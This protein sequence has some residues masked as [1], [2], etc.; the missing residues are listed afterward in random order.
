MR[1]NEVTAHTKSRSVPP[2]KCGR[3]L[4]QLSALAV[5]L[6]TTVTAWAQSNCT[7]S[8]GPYA[9]G[10]SFYQNF[11]DPANIQTYGY[12][13]PRVGGANNVG[14]DLNSTYS[15][16]F[17]SISHATASG[18]GLE[19]VLV[20]AFSDAR[21]FSVT[22]NDMHY[23]ATQHLADFE[24]DPATQ[25]I[26][27]PF[28]KL[29]SYAQSQIYMVPIGL[30][31]IPASATQGCGIS[32]YEE[33]N[34][35]DATQR[36]PS[37]DWNADLTDPNNGAAHYVDV[38][39]HG[40]STGPPPPTNN[41][42]NTA[43]SITVRSYLSPSTCNGQ[44]G[45]GT[46]H[47]NPTD[48]P[49]TPYIIFR[50][51]ASGCAYPIATA[52]SNGWVDDPT[53]QQPISHPTT[54]VVSTV[55]RANTNNGGYSGW[56]DEPQ[57]YNHTVNTNLIP[58]ACYAYGNTGNNASAVA[59]ARSP[60]WLGSPG[61]DDSY[62]GGAISAAHLNDVLTGSACGSSGPCVLRFRFQLPPNTAQT[63]C[64]SPYT[65]QLQGNEQLRYMSVT[66]EYEPNSNDPN[67]QYISDP[68]GL[69]ASNLPSPPT[70]IVSIADVAFKP[71]T[72]ASGNNY[73]TL[74]VNLGGTLPQ[75]LAQNS[76][77]YAVTAPQQGVT[78]ATV[79]GNYSLWWING[80]TVLD[81]SKLSAFQ[82]VC[83]PGQQCSLPLLINVRNT[84]PAATFGC[85]GAAV[86]YNTAVFTNIDGN[87]ATLMGPFVPAVDYRNPSDQN[88]AHQYY[89]PLTAGTG[90]LASAS[91]C[92]I[93]PSAAQAVPG[94]TASGV[95]VNYPVQYWTGTGALNCTPA[96]VRTPNITFVAT[97]RTTLA[98]PTV[99]T[100]GSNPPVTNACTQIITQASEDQGQWK[101]A[102]PL[103]IVGTGFGFLPETM[104]PMAAGSSPYLEV[105]SDGAG[106][107]QP[108]DSSHIPFWELTGTPTGTCQIYIANWMDS[109]ISLVL[110]IPAGVSNST[111]ALPL[112]A[113]EDIS[114]QTFMFP[115]P[116]PN[117]PLPCPVQAQDNLTFTITNPQSSPPTAVPFPPFTVSSYTNTAPN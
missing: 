51:T 27:N 42:P 99:C 115:L 54:A 13:L 82:N 10:T 61:P 95:S 18:C 72:D 68:D 84:L 50:D 33:D 21:Y 67:Q 41:G 81:L 92:G 83:P 55:D 87:G 31:T 88:P 117:A 38:P 80:Y 63:P 45:S 65:C 107:G 34:L 46:V 29:T 113:P 66:L 23:S 36:H 108:W 16:M 62:I 53:A 101:P 104:L 1:H 2:S 78:P 76:T 116:Y 111:K 14:G 85:S 48:P 97:Q 106:S 5:C 70:S 44:P 6:L 102:L 64:P 77:A 24:M 26:P 32:P 11:A 30:G 9:Q 47:C 4:P 98:T 74:L 79:A 103:K 37:M 105:S 112:L 20:G 12:P 35:L 89:L 25:Q 94:M 39:S 43:G 75:T 57:H 96:G 90:G 114:F 22:D 40:A 93:L 52:I 58:Q 3:N 69:N 91:Y 56:N 109:S 73:A 110:G 17:Y 100:P 71:T 86:P 59:F 8:T 7:P 28:E 49:S 15:Q 19:L 60:E